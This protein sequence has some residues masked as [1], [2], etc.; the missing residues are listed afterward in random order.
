M[1]DLIFRIGYT[2]IVSLIST[3]PD[4]FS[5]SH[6]PIP[7]CCREVPASCREVLASCREVLASCREAPASCREVPTCCREVPASCREVPASCRDAPTSCRDAP[8]SCR[9]AP[10][11]CR[12]AP[13]SCREVP[14]SHFPFGIFPYR[15]TAWSHHSETSRSPCGVKHH[16]EAQPWQHEAIE[17]KDTASR[18]GHHKNNS[19]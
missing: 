7:T 14:G 10:T 12:D 2:K 11:S 16:Q 8:T 9:D 4:P 3:D 17:G 19:T 6:F 13:T 15:D 1:V 5:G 18:Q